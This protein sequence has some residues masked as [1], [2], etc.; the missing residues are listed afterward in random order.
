MSLLTTAQRISSAGAGSDD[1][2]GVMVELAPEMNQWIA[3]C[4]PPAASPP[5][6]PNT[7]ADADE[8][9][10]W[11]DAWLLKS[12]AMQATPHHINVMAHHIRRKKRKD[13]TPISVSDAD[14]LAQ[15]LVD[16]AKTQD[17]ADMTQDILESRQS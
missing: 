4:N 10:A 5:T 12:Y 16:N 8:Q 13:G 14:G 6:N 3:S 15:A 7:A 1:L 11:S 2:A 9:K 17:M